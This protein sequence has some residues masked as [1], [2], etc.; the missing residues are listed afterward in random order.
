MDVTGYLD[1]YG[2]DARELGER[3]RQ[4]VSPIASFSEHHRLFNR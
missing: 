4:D 3:I 2:C 1:L